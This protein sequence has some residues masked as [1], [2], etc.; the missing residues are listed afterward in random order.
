M[1]LSVLPTHKHF[2]N[3]HQSIGDDHYFLG[4]SLCLDKSISGLGS[5]ILNISSLADNSWEH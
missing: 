1:A 5:N 2:E 3:E 4:F